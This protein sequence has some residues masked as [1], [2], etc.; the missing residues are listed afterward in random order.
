MLSSNRLSAAILDVFS[1][2]PIAS[3]SHIWNVPNLIVSPHISADDGV[4][5]IQDTLELFFK[6][7]NYFILK[8]PLIK[9]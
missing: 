3:N 2:E 1:P 8:K 4:N 7:L 5:Y 6:N 9:N